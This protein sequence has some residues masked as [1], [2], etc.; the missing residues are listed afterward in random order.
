MLEVVMV[1]VMNRIPSLWW[2]CA[3]ASPR[4]AGMAVKADGVSRLLA[5]KGS[6]LLRSEMSLW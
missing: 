3:V 5:Q 6:S 2:V 1:L 4:M